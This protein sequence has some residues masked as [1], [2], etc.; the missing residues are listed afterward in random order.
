MSELSLIERMEKFKLPKIWLAEIQRMQNIIDELVEK[1]EEYLTTIDTLAR[2][3]E[4]HLKDENE[5]QNQDQ[6]A[7]SDTR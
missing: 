5:I 1:N 7:R 2:Q 3:L 6:A 4:R